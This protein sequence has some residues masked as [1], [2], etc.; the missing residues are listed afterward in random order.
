MRRSE[1]AARYLRYAN[2]RTMATPTINMATKICVNEILIIPLLARSPKT[3]TCID[4]RLTATGSN[5][6]ITD[7]PNTGSSACGRKRTLDICEFP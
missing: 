3:G 7:K 6:V 2:T 1:F 5:Y 4:Y